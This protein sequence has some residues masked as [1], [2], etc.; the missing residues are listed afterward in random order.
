MDTRSRF[1][2]ANRVARAPLWRASMCRTAPRSRQLA[3]ALATVLGAAS[4][5]GMAAPMPHAVARGRD[6]PSRNTILWPVTNCNDAGADSL[7]DAAMHALDGD[8]IDLSGLTCSTISV[9]SGAITLGDVDLIGPGAG[10]LTINGAGNGLHRIFNHAGHGGALR[11][12][13]VTVHGAKYESDAGKGGGCLRSDG[14]QLRVYDSVFDGCLAF[15]PTG[16]SGSVRGGAIAAYGSYVLLSHVTLSGNQARSADG[17]ALG[18]ALY[19]RNNLTMRDSTIT[20]N[21]AT[22]VGASATVRGGGVFVHGAAAIMRSSID[23]NVCE[24]FG[25]GVVIETGGMLVDSTVSN[26]AASGGASGIAFLGQNQ[27]VARVYDST[28]SGNDTQASTQWGSGALYTNGPAKIVGSTIA[29][30]TESNLDGISWGAGILFGPVTDSS[31][32]I[33]ISTIV[34]G[35][36]I[37]DFP[38]GAD[39]GGPLGVTIS[40]NHDL[41]GVSLVYVPVDTIRFDDP[42]LGPLQDNGGPTWTRMPAPDSVVIDHGDDFNR[43]TDQRGYARVVGLAADIGAVEVQSTDAIFADDFDG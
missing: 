24:G 26:N 28:I 15:A 1:L 20:D 39:I 41:I 35:N 16:T 31:Y 40:G 4:G 27:I 25:G 32:L 7:R 30:N 12:R 11:I 19:L 33:M 3:W 36:H 6:A 42:L 14:G 29:G 8:A 18:G 22:A 43:E 9:T 34:S 17:D 21:S 2:L 10:A 5:A 38:D 13:D 23:G 37:S